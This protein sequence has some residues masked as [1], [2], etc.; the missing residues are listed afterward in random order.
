MNVTECVLI[1]WKHVFL[2]TFCLHHIQ[3]E[4][5]SWKGSF[6]PA[7]FSYYHSYLI[8]FLKLHSLSLQRLSSALTPP[9]MTVETLIKKKTTQKA[10]SSIVTL[11]VDSSHRVFLK[12]VLTQKHH[13]TSPAVD[14][15]TT[16]RNLPPVS[17][18]AFVVLTQPT[19]PS[20]ADLRHINIHHN[21]GGK[22]SGRF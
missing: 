16:Q 22:H 19:A 7:A 17:S 15:E 10:K 3:S 21:T 5:Q 20:G 14:H 1:C 13:F 11:L 12:S 6:Y 4:L 18:E 2:W 9:C 8:C